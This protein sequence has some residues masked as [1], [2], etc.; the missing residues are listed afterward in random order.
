MDGGS[1]EDLP[2]ALR[3]HAFAALA[4]RL[5][6]DHRA[7]VDFLGGALARAL[8]GAVTV[9]RRGLL[10]SGG[11]SSVEVQLGP[12][13]YELHL[14]HGRTET[15]IAQVVGGVVLRHDPVPVEAWVEGLLGDLERMARD[16][17]SARAALERLLR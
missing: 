1:S 2:E 14:R 16:S 3:L 8:P 15:V 9:H 17:E 5:E 10:R 6:A 12:R 11:V 13:Q 4:G 7:L